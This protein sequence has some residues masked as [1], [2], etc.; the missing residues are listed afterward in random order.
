MDSALEETESLRGFGLSTADVQA[1]GRTLAE[2][3]ALLTEA[4]SGRTLSEALKVEVSAFDVA[5]AITATARTRPAA[6]RLSMEE[7]GHRS[8]VRQTG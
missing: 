4:A 7:T 5:N 1:V 6:A 2:E 8:L 3:H